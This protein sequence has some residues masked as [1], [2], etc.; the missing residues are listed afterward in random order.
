MGL[1]R[2]YLIAVDMGYEDLRKLAASKL[3]NTNPELSQ[4]IHQWAKDFHLVFS[5]PDAGFR[6]LTL[7]PI[8][9]SQLAQFL[10]PDNTNFAAGDVDLLTGKW[11][12]DYPQTAIYV[13]CDYV[14]TEIKSDK[15]LDFYAEARENHK[16]L[17]ENV[18]HYLLGID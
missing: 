1:R 8:S 2:K 12:E 11:F 18:Q 6:G 9:S 7:G 14:R 10:E 3:L 17:V 4:S 15:L 16:T 13:D 5:A